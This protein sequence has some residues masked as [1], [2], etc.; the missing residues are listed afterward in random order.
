MKQNANLEV[1]V[2]RKNILGISN[3]LFSKTLYIFFKVLQFS[4]LTFGSFLLKLCTIMFPK[5]C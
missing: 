4:F 3:L 5:T 1:F 2:G